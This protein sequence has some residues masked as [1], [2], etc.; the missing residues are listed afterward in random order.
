LE[1]L[2]NVIP[3]LSLEG[4]REETDDRR[5]TGVYETLRRTIRKLRGRRVFW[6]LSFTVTSLNFSMI[7]NE[8]HIRGL[9]AE[10]GKSFFFVEYVPVSKGTE[11][12]VLTEEQKAMMIRS[13]N[14]FRSRLAGLFVMFPGDEDEFGGCLSSGRGFVHVNAQGRLEPCPFAPYSDVS[15]EDMPL[16]EA[17]K[18]DL[19]KKIRENHS[20]LRETISG[21]ALWAKRDWVRGLAG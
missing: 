14:G 19:L 18:S 4:Y 21:C 9:I 13:V 17:L 8:K 3:I 7:V 16:R 1:H 5:G 12:L 15:L 11:G 6:G 20:E 10:G 2:P